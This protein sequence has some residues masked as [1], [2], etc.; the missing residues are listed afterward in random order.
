VHHHNLRRRHFQAA[1]VAAGRCAIAKNEC[2][3]EHYEGVRFHDLRHT[4]AALLIAAGRHL[5]EVKTYFGHTSIRVTSDL[6][7]HLFP[8]ARAAIADALETLVP[9][10]SRA[11]RGLSA[12]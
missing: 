9:N 3:R 4:C 1:A 7:G 2:G 10:R 6:Y 8:E 5:E 11:T 12:A